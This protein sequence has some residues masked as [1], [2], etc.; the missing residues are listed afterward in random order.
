MYTGVAAIFV[1]ESG[2]EARRTASRVRRV[3]R[4][5]GATLRWVSCEKVLPRGWQ[6]LVFGAGA[7]CVE[8][9]MPLRKVLLE[10]GIRRGGR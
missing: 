6:G 7:T 3:M 2:E 5:R 10:P 1:S 4:R 9:D 8:D